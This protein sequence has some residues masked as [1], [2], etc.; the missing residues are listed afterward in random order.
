MYVCMYVC[1]SFIPQPWLAI[2]VLTVRKDI[3]ERLWLWPGEP[4]PPPVGNWFPQPLEPS[5]PNRF[6]VV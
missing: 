6:N 5:S 1:N 2:G 3:G 4:V